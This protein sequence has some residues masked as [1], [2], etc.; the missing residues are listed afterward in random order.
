MRRLMVS[1]VAVVVVFAAGVSYAQES[2][3]ASMPEKVRKFLDNMTGTWR[4]DD[5][6]GEGKAEIRWDS[7][8]GTLIESGQ[9]QY[10]DVFGTWTGL[11]YWDG[12]SEDGVIGC[13]S[14]ST[15]YGFAHGKLRGKVLS[16]TAME[17]QGTG[18]RAGKKT[19]GNIRIEFKGPDQYT[20]SQTN[21]IVGGEK[22]PDSTT[23]STRVKG[24]SDE[25]VLTKL[26]NESVDALLKRDVAFLARL[27][28]DD[29]TFESSDGTAITKDQALGSIKSGTYAVTSMTYDTLKVRIYGST[30]VTSGFSTEKSQFMGRDTSGQYIFT[31]TWIKRDGRWLCVATHSSKVAQG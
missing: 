15:R 17:G 20:V 24:T 13:A 14:V 8:K 12:I 18:V 30:A 28:A 11:W 7:G 26:A 4:S 19:S 29:F 21:M 1:V 22:R 9:F 27:L 6:E 5:G 23:V 2:G 3:P 10:G 25:Q 16:K 31:D